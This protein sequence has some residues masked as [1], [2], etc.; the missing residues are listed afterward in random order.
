MFVEQ[1]RD[2]LKSRLLFGHT[3]IRLLCFSLVFGFRRK[4]S[5]ERKRDS[6]EEKEKERW[7]VEERV[8]EM[9]RERRS[10]R[11]RQRYKT[12]TEGARLT[13]RERE[14]Y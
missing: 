12:E 8:R 2:E 10:W 5:S 9:V 1:W 4:T 3:W 11:Y 13:V 7:I 14:N 6:L